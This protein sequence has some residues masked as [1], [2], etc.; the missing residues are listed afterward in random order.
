MKLKTLKVGTWAMFIGLLGLASCK[1]DLP[2]ALDTSPQM[3]VLTS[4]K[5]VN[6]GENGTTVLTGTI[7][8]DAKTVSFP[9]IDPKTNFA[10][11]KF[12]A[13]TSDGAKLDK[14]VY[15][16]TFDTDQ[17]EKVIVVKVVNSPRF[18][19]YLV[20]L[21]LKV[22][23]FGADFE[24]GT[25][26]DFTNNPLG[27]PLYASFSG[28]ATRGSGFDGQKVLIV[29]RTGG[30]HLLDVA[31]LKK[32]VINKIPINI[33]GVSQGTFTVNM[34]AQVKGH[35]YIANLSSNTAASPLKVYHWTNPS[36]APEVIL[37][38]NVGTINGAGVRYGDNF[39]AS[40]D[41]Q[42][43][44][45]FFFGDNAATKVL[46]FDVANYTTVTNPTVFAMPVTGA[47]SWTSF[48]RI[49]NTSEYLFTGHDAPVALISE[50]GVSAFTMSRTAIPVRGSDAR[51]V[52]FNSER[53]LIVTTAARTGSEATNFYVYD[54][55]KGANVKEALT[56]LN[57]LPTVTPVFQY[58][59]M[60][61][62]NTSPAS[63]T[64][65][66]VKKDAAGNDETLMLYSAASDA[67]FVF[68]E[69]GKKVAL[70]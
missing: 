61:P 29:W 48:N 49:G 5:I 45:Y 21:R 38:I 67:G 31:E 25:T 9:R 41:D 22:P 57:S 19:E 10:N 6:A 50:S 13:V 24:K 47:G 44:G 14:E 54:I 42:G 30:P 59:L 12:E 32:G 35:T 40:L 3:T 36:S 58:S 33:T 52:N 17:T 63:Q 60:G 43:N 37:N 11:L 20:K 66:Y 2:E 51:I 4:I 68:F 16:V 7:D 39:S 8:E 64:G 53:Y 1:E 23:V 28:A 65:F 62:V 34:G 69:F 55:T 70:D 27:D 46:R 18:R 26:Y 56:N 15:P